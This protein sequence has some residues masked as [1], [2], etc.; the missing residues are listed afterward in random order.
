M[1]NS[2]LYQCE[3]SEKNKAPIPTIDPEISNK[4]KDSNKEKALP[5]KKGFIRENL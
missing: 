3:E 5:L 4:R 1:T 2:F